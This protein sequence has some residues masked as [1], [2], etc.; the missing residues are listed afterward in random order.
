MN[1]F[2][3][4]WTNEMDYAASRHE[5]DDYAE[6]EIK[7]RERRAAKRAWNAALNEMR[8]EC[9]YYISSYD[10]EQLDRI[11]QELKIDYE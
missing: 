2:D 8:E 7:L 4:W 1:E 11:K 10:Q 6:S 5:V 9:K 3:K